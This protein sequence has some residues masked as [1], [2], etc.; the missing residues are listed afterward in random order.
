M[1]PIGIV[2][3]VE[4]ND[5]TFI[6][7]MKLKSGDFVA[8]KD[9]W[10]DRDRFVLCRVRYAKSLKE[11]PDEFLMNSDLDPNEVLEFS[12]M[13]TEE[14]SK[15]LIIA[16]IVGYFSESLKEFKHPR[17]MPD[18]GEMVYLAGED[19]LG[20][21]SKMSAGSIGSAA[22]GTVLGTEVPV[23]L[24][25]KDLVSQHLSIIAATGSGKSYTVGV[26]LEELMKPNN[27]AAVLVVDPHG[28]YSTLT[29]I[30]NLPSFIQDDYRPIV[31]VLRKDNI[32]IKVTELEL[33]DFLSILDMTDKMEAFFIKAYHSL[34]DK[35]S[36]K[37]VD[38][39]NEVISLRD[40]N[41]QST[42]DGILWRYD[43]NIMRRPIFDD[44]QHIPLKDQFNVGQLSILDLSGLSHKEQQLISAV[45]LRRLF[46]AREGTVNQ[47]YTEKVERYLPYPV[48]VVLEEAHRFAPQNGETKAKNILKTILAEGR[49]FGIGVCMVSQR[50]SKLDSDCLSQCMSQITMRIINPVDKSQVAASIESM[51]QDILDELPALA[52][53]EAI[54]SGVAI[55]TPTMV[56]VRT[57]LTQHGGVSR[58]A[59]EEWASYWNKAAALKVTT[60]TQ[61]QQYKLF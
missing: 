41:N 34:A 56:K 45:L 28:E 33:E 22:I 48:F 42:I 16:S 54:I 3:G 40:E 47:R 44:Y 24:S 51:S 39:Q 23:V 50:P 12:G 2:R 5:I 55:N 53:G 60:I 25:V 32:K 19:I 17:T 30:Q 35:K 38:L 9:K 14:Y 13:D 59:P 15:Y 49:K 31:K 8:Y 21:V 29:G 61:K 37:K 18:S 46:D 36:F 11:Y 7:S 6:A 52:K 43:S 57:R 58:D 1:K 20:D 10:V 27:R 26:L 4:G